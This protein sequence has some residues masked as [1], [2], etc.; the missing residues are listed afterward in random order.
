M[1]GPYWRYRL[2]PLYK[3]NRRGGPQLRKR[4]RPTINLTSTSSAVNNVQACQSMS[5][6]SA[7]TSS[8]QNAK[9][10]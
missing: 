10:C 3:A 9:V 2:Y 6:S 4:D 1:N 8:G 5:K 7:A